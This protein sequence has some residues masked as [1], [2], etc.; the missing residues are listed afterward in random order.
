MQLK[1]NE[2]F[3]G[4]ML[5]DAGIRKF[6]TNTGKSQFFL[7]QTKRTEEMVYKTMEE[8]KLF[9][10][11]GFIREEKAY[12]KSTEKY[13]DLIY[14][15]THSSVE[16]GEERKRWYPL[17][18]KIVPKD[19]N[20]TPKILAY[21]FMGDGNSSFANDDRS[22]SLTLETQSFT[23]QDN[24]YLATRLSQDLGIIANVNK[25]R[26]NFVLRI[27]KANQVTKFMDLVKPYMLK[28]FEYKIKYPSLVNLGNA[29]SRTADAQKAYYHA[30]PLKVRQQRAKE[31]WERKKKLGINEARK[32]RYQNDPEYRKK[33][34]E[35]ARKNYALIAQKA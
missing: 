8:M 25:K 24:E 31:Q 16:I 4:L 23:K 12:L 33:C 28:C 21:W 17:G 20:L 27:Q 7:K 22:V 13:Y 11:T 15:M 6:R 19:L 35:R 34:Q 5:S 9:G 3:L 29:P 30:L 26:G 10:I 1:E 2:L 14:Y 18:I 32:L